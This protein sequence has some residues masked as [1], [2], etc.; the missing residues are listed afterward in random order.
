MFGN[1]FRC[2]AIRT[3]AGALIMLPGPADTVR[4]W[5]EQPR[6]EQ[7]PTFD[8]LVNITLA[9]ADHLPKAQ[10]TVPTRI[11]PHP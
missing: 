7:R 4:E 5:L 3:V 1:L 6:A 8:L 11:Y 9:A 2:Q 10:P